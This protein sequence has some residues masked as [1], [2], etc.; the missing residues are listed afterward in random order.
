LA[1]LPLTPRVAPIAT[2]DSVVVVRSFDG[3]QDSG[4]V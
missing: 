4:V 1:A 3:A 2:Q